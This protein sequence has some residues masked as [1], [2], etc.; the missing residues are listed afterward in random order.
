MNQA[1]PWL[2]MMIQNLHILTLTSHHDKQH[3]DHAAQ[4]SQTSFIWGTKL[5][6]ENLDKSFYKSIKI[7]YHLLVQYLQGTSHASQR[8]TESL[9][10]HL[11]WKWWWYTHM[12]AKS[13]F[14]SVCSHFNKKCCWGDGSVGT[15]GIKCL[16]HKHEGYS[17]DPQHFHECWVAE[18]V[19]CH[20]I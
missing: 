14:A 5:R 18:I 7:Y 6:K 4:S 20:S 3:P 19:C 13:M 10:Q 2:A 12:Y 11:I 8:H 9:L 16:S 1:M 17:S 15:A